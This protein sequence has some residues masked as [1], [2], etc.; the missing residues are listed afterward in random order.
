M[1]VTSLTA[2]IVAAT[3][4][5]VA[6]AAM[7]SQIRSNKANT[8]QLDGANKNFEKETAKIK[9]L[10]SSQVDTQAQITALNNEVQKLSEQ[11]KDLLGEIYRLRKD[12]GLK[13]VD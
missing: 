7:V 11:N 13:N 4:A 8:K 6:L 9:M 3:P 1:D 5:V 10:V 12:L 2:I